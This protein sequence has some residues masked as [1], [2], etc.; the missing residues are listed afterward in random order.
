MDK[1]KVTDQL[2]W[3]RRYM[4]V[5]KP[6]DEYRRIYEVISKSAENSE[7]KSFIHVEKFSIKIKD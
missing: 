3:Q 2:N 1:K 4:R 5:S 7:V 6:K